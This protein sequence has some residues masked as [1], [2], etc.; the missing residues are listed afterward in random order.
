MAMV[1]PL[2]TPALAAFFPNAAVIVLILGA[3]VAPLRLRGGAFAIPPALRPIAVCVS[4]LVAWAA[5][6]A[7]WS[8]QPEQSLVRALKIAALGICGLILLRAALRLDEE[9]RRLA[10]L[11]LLIGLCLLL[12]QLAVEIVTGGMF[13]GILHPS[14]PNDPSV[15][16]LN[17]RNG[18][19]VLA[20]FLW[21]G[22]VIAARRFSL[23]AAVAFVLLSVGLTLYID[24]GSAGL[25]LI[26][27]GLAMAFVR[28]GPRRASAVIVAVSVLAVVIAP[29]LPSALPAGAWMRDIPDSMRVS[30]YHRSKIW[31][32]TAERIWRRPI[33][34]WGM[35]GARSLPGGDYLY[36]I[37][38]DLEYEKVYGVLCDLPGAGGSTQ[39]S[40]P[41]DTGIR[42]PCTQPPY[43]IVAQAMPLHPHN[44]SLQLWLELGAVG[45]LLGAA[46]VF[47][48]Q[49]AIKRARYSAADTAAAFAAFAAA[50]VVAGLSYGIWQSWWHSVLWLT[51]VILV[52]IARPANA[53]PA[54]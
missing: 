8:I 34:G 40:P 12:L 50:F 16:L 31:S 41:G 47:L 22:A 44:A 49:I 54:Q 14:V 32:F 3:L 13:T 2:A 30:V 17:L 28:F 10:G 46:L 52:G 15:R 48:A 9:E 26:V 53:E 6:S 19:A 39:A 11:G 20:I 24:L 45:A 18:T 5:L 4:A 23:P 29:V 1:I 35:D 21:P 36:D 51:S 38:R 27:G 43:A 37:N 25:A 42:E 33:L 7:V